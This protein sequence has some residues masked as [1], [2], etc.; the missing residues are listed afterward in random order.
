MVDWVM[1]GQATA[2][3]IVRCRLKL[4]A[5]RKL[6]LAAGECGGWLAK[7]R[8]TEG[9]DVAGEVGVVEDVEGGDAG[10]EDFCFVPFFFGEAEVVVVQ[11]VE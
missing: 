2:R 3:A 4:E 6:E 1:E 10:G 5:H 8:R 11:E 9:S 7:A